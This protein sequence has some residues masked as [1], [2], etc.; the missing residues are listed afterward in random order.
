MKKKNYFQ[1]LL[2]LLGV[3][4]LAVFFSYNFLLA[5]V[6]VPTYQPFGNVTVTEAGLN[7]I[8]LVLPVL[9]ITLILIILLKFLGFK[10]FTYI[11]SILPLG[12]AVLI[13]PVFIFLTVNNYLPDVADPVALVSTALLAFAIFYST[14]KHVH[15]LS[16][17]STFI[18][19]A[20]VGTLFALILQPPTLFIVLLAFAIYDIYAVF[21]GP[22][23]IF[24]SELTKS[25]FPIVKKP[26]VSK[27][28]QSLDLGIFTANIG[29]LTIGTGDLVF[30]SL[31]TAAAFLIKGVVAVVAALAAVN[32]GVVLT[33]F[34]LMKYKKML[35]GLPLPIFLGVLTLI[36]FEYVLT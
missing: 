27:I 2:F 12:I 14:V 29:G 35:P 13:N 1:V 26:S 34:I 9:I 10:F 28:R 20:E 17:I 22:L 25:R 30:Y 19:S 11:L 5:N 31:I 21:A 32:F 7:A 8:F 4:L 36:V 3:Q 33:F 18:I 16:N 15:W 23:K 6:E 24:I